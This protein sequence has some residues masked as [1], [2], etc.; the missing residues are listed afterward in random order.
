MRKIHGM[1]ARVRGVRVPLPVEGLVT[2]RLLVMEYLD[3]VPLSR[4]EGRVAGRR[5]MRRVG[6]A[7][8][9][10]MGEAYGEMILGEGY[11]QAD[12]HPGMCVEREWARGWRVEFGVLLLLTGCLAI[13]STLYIDFFMCLV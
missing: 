12:P 13:L 4:L 10:R 11:W 9:K 2:P 6:R 5:A 1:L 8:M 7:I 3:G